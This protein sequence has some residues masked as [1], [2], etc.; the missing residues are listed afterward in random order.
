MDLDRGA[1][2]RA[3]LLEQAGAERED[4]WRRA[5]RPIPGTPA[6]PWLR[7]G[8]LG[9]FTDGELFI[10]G[11]MKDIL[12]IRGRNHYPEDIESTV[13]E[14]T[15]GRVAAISV[16]AGETEKLVLIIEYRTPRNTGVGSCRIRHQR[17]DSCD[18]PR[19]WADCRRP[20]SGGPGLH[21]D[22]D[23]GK[24][25]RAA[26][27]DLYLGQQFTPPGQL[28]GAAGH[29]A[30]RPRHGFGREQRNRSGWG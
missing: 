21:S 5:S 20:G 7:T 29:V 28:T 15:R 8:D 13:S 24:I 4:L 14:I 11:R 2:C 23:G 17:R 22:H 6:G 30:D 18:R 3:G 25:R 26:C 19:P 27:G 12:I 1:Q 16:T 10:V 9:F